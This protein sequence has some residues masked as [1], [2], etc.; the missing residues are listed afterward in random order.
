MK[1]TAQ[2]RMG[3]GKASRTNAGEA[4]RREGRAKRRIARG[5]TDSL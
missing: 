2:H 3:F 4:G 5:K 1:A